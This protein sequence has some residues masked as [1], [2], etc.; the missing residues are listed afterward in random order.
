MKVYLTTSPILVLCTAL[1]ACSGKAGAADPEQEKEV[2]ATATVAGIPVGKATVEERILSYGT[3]EFPAHRQRTLTFLYEGQ[4][5]QVPVVAGESV[6][7][8]DELLRV[9]PVAKD[10]P[11]VQQA[12]IDAEYAVRELDRTRRLV[13]QK[14]ATNQDLQNAE[15]QSL[16]AAAS[17]R[18]LGGGGPGGATIRAPSDG[19]VASVP[20]HRGD[21]VQV[22][23]PAIVIADHNAMSV[24]AGFEVS[25]LSRLAEGLAVRIAPVYGDREE[26]TA[27]AKL[28]TLHRVADPKT[29]L[30]EGIIQIDEIPPW[31]AAGLSTR[32]HVILRSHEDVLVVPRDALLEHDGATGVFAIEN[33]HAKFQPLKL[34]IGDD[35][36]VEVLAGLSEG[37]RVVTTG[38]TS[39][40]DGMAVNDTAKEE[41]SQSGSGSE[42]EKEKEK[43]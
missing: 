4:V 31:M 22:G 8:G 42:D 40:E 36:N 43:P 37:S 5:T 29:Q 41:E 11:R 6:K 24:R 38:R 34:G 21:V 28:S 33:E 17:L 15:K 13:E 16:A 3:V 27:K 25:D 9:G 23:D 30:V 12:N 10:S 18:A 39:L 35:D 32:V 20:V 19:I 14:L 2:H 1:A 7:R 26:P